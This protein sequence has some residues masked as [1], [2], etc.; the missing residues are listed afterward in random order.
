MSVDC[1]P[2]RRD[3]PPPQPELSTSPA[4]EFNASH[5]LVPSACDDPWLQAWDIHKEYVCGEKSKK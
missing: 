2:T 4:L 1:E 3:Q 5:G